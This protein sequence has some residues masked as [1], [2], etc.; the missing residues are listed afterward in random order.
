MWQGTGRPG[1][2]CRNLG[3]VYEDVII[4]L[5]TTGCDAG[6]V[7]CYK[8]LRK[9][10]VLDWCTGEIGGH[11]QII[12]VADVE[13][14]S[15]LYPDTVIVNMEVWT[16]TGRWEVPPAWIVDNCS[17]ELH[18]TVEVEEGTVLGNDQTGYVVIDMPQGLQNGY[19]V[20]TDCCGNITKKLVK[21]NVQ[22]NVPPNCNTRKNTG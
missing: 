12:K 18:Y 14:P 1:A 10:T 16:C 3:T 5:S 19:I 21:L 7:G 13:G 2:N 9:W 22:D 17:K 20:A 11:S 4:P 15:V 8:V 6:P